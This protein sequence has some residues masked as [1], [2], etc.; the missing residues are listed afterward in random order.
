DIAVTSLNTNTVSILLN[1][2]NGTFANGGTPAT[3]VGP[4]GIAA[5]DFD[6]GGDTDPRGDNLNA[7]TPSTPLHNS[8][9]RFTPPPPTATGSN[10]YAV[11]LGDLD[12]D[13]DLDIATSNSGSSTVSVFRNNGSGGFT[14]ADGS[15]FTVGLSPGGVVM[16]DFDE[17]R[18]LDLATANFGSN[19]A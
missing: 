6:G 11:T 9:G 10:P 15:P 14:P 12:G 2:P 4:R 3:G 1:N 5:G 7:T 16:G 8:A 13:G 17:D 18:V 19:T